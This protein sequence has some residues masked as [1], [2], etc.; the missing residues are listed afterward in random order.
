MRT[1]L[2]ASD[3]ELLPYVATTAAASAWSSWNAYAYQSRG[4]GDRPHPT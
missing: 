2:F 1:F 4:L 3:D